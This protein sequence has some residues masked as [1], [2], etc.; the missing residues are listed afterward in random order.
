[1]DLLRT[2][3]FVGVSPRV[4]NL[5]CIGSMRHSITSE[6]GPHVTI[7][8][9]GCETISDVRE[10]C[11]PVGRQSVPAYRERRIDRRKG[12]AFSVAL[13]ACAM[14]GS[15]FPM[16]AWTADLSS[17]IPV[18]PRKVVAAGVGYETG[19]TSLITVKTYDAEN[20]AILSDDTYEL[21]V[22]ED[23]ASADSH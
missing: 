17:L 13:I 15:I 3:P 12:K 1:P 16:A 7:I 20:G 10:W 18:K 2:P 6:G 14:I 5:R 4:G 11:E 21:N 22:R 9:R 8:H 23:V 19:E